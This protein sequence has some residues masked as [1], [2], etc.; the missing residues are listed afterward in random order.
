MSVRRFLGANSR[1]AMRQVREA[2]GDEALILANR[3]TGQGVEILAMAE[4]AVAAS[5]ESSP[6]P[7]V[8]PVAPPATTS[9]VQPSP[10][11][12]SS[13]A[14]AAMSA[15]LLEEMRDMRELL[16]RERS[17]PASTDS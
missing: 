10:R 11:D 3:Q 5:S 4:S 9:A 15:Q 2:L 12:D 13:Q 17:R 16:A 6:V 7:P 1:E 14:F 8:S